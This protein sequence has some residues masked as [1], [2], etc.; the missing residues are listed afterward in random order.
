[1][2]LHEATEANFKTEILEASKPIVVDFW[3]EWCGP[4]KMMTPVLEAVSEKYADQLSIYKLDTDAN[5]ETAA[6][7]EITGIPCCI[8]FKDGEE[9]GRIVGFRSEDAFV[10]E[11]KKHIEL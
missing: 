4:C 9:A 5:Q 6:T 8:I 11:L 2:A 3:A 7:Y 10:D 1:M